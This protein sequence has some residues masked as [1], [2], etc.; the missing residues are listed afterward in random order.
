MRNEADRQLITDQFKTRVTF[1]SAH[2]KLQTFC[3]ALVLENVS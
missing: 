3:P 1:S 2:Q